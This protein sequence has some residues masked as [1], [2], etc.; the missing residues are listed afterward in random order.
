MC[1][2]FSRVLIGKMGNAVIQAKQIVPK[3][4]VILGY[5]LLSHKG[6]SYP[7][8]Y[9]FY[10][11]NFQFGHTVSQK[12]LFAHLYWN[13]MMR[14]IAAQNMVCWLCVCKEANV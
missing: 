8:M 7:R 3:K 4:P 11:A 12:S 9:V 5:F 1:S 13:L 10:G 14:S 6:S 2:G